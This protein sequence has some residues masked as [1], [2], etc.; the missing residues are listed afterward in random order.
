MWTT[1][2]AGISF[3]L[4]F[5][6]F[7][8]KYVD[9]PRIDILQWREILDLISRHISHTLEKIRNWSEVYRKVSDGQTGSDQIILKSELNNISSI[10]LQ[11]QAPPPWLL[12]M[13]LSQCSCW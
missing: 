12:L 6:E 7:K 3:H 8:E 5:A 13:K 2:M 9:Q 4:N 1:V 11:H 10:T